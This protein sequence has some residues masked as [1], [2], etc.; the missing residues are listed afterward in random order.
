MKYLK[1]VS[2]FFLL[3]VLVLWSPVGRLVERA[4]DA[5][6]AGMHRRQLADRNTAL[7]RWECRLLYG[8]IVTLGGLRYPEGAAVIDHYLHGGG[9]DLR[10]ASDYIRRSPVVRRR[11]AALP[12]NQTAVV[13]LRQR[14]DWRLSYALNPF[15][16]RR[17]AHRVVIYQ[18]IAFDPRPA[19]RTV[20]DLGLLRL[21]V[22]D[23]LVHVLHPRPYM[24]RCEWF[25][26]STPTA[27]GGRQR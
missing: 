8:G 5:H 17:E 3:V 25:E 12:L 16:L 14:E 10:L 21:T 22:P 4:V 6:L 20:L 23:G 18:W 19:V 2:L 9:R 11:L 13:T 27:R 26:E 24:A 1:R 7:D 15:R